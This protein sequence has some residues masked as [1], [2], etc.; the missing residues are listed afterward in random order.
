MVDGNN[1]ES[2][3]SALRQR[4]NRS[5]SACGKDHPETVADEVALGRFLTGHGRAHEAVSMLRHAVNAAHESPAHSDAGRAESLFELALALDK[6]G[7]DTEAMDV[8]WSAYFTFA[9]TL[10]PAATD[11]VLSALNLAE[12]ARVARDFESAER[13]FHVVLAAIHDVHASPSALAAHALNNLAETLLA[14]GRADE[15]APLAEEGLAIRKTLF[16]VASPEYT[17]S[18]CVVAG[19]AA[20]RGDRKR[21]DDAIEELRASS[22]PDALQLP[23]DLI[24]AYLETRGDFAQAVEICEKALAGLENQEQP[25]DESL[26]PDQRI[27]IRFMLAQ[28]L[29]RLDRWSEARTR[30]FE[31]FRIETTF[32]SDAARHR[33]QRQ[34]RLMLGESRRRIATLFDLISRTPDFAANDARDVYE[35]I[36]QRKS[37]ETR[38]LTLQK[39]SFITDR[40]LTAAPPERVEQLRAHLVEVVGDLRSTRQEWL[41]ALLVQSGRQPTGGDDFRLLALQDN[42]ERLERHLASFVGEGSC[43]WAIL[44]ITS[45]TPRLS[46]GEAIVEYFFVEAPTPMYYAFVVAGDEV[47]LTGLGDAASIHQALTQLRVHIVND[48]PR[49]GHPDPTWRRR[50]RFLAN[51]LLR[52]LLPWLDGA[53]TLYV[54]PDAELFTLPFDLL[55]LEDGSLAIDQWTITHLWNGG[56]RAG[57]HV[58]FGS[59]DAPDQAV[60]V[61]ASTATP[62]AS[63]ETPRF[64]P[65]TFARREAIAIAEKI[66]ATHL[67]ADAA[68]KT[69]VLDCGRAEILHFASHSFWIPRRVDA[70]VAPTAGAETPLFR[71]RSMIADPM[72]RSGIA[73]T[74]ADRELNTPTAASPGILFASEVLDLDLRDT[75]LAVL[76]SCQSGIG[77]PR[78]GDGIQGL[79]RAFRAA[80]AGSVVSSLWKVPDEATHDLMV[81]FYNHILTEV[82][83]GESL[84][85][86]KLALRERYPDDPLSWA[87]FVLD[88]DDRP[89]FRFSPIRGLTLATL[90]GVGLSFDKAMEDI[91]EGQ[92]DD[93][94]ESLEFVMESQTADDDL[95]ADAAIERAGVLRQQGHTDESLSA[96]KAIIDDVRTPVDHMRRAVIER[97]LT[98]HMAGDMKGAND[99][100]TAALSDT[101]LPDDERAWMLVNRG[102]VLSSMDD[103]DSAIADWSEVLTITGAS[104]GQRAKALL[105]RANLYLRT[106]AVTHAIADATELAESPDYADF[107]ERPKAHLILALCRLEQ[108]DLLSA[109]DAVHEH[110][111]LRA[112]PAP[113]AIAR[114][115]S[116]SRTPEQLT[117]LIRNLL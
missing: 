72:L 12:T 79:R 36:Q 44:G 82:P 20:N 10:G 68:T 13:W 50:A 37:L 46:E 59:P 98:K 53:R 6:S 15:A 64:A 43:D 47:H 51:R 40:A 103:D 108:G 14:A 62:D 48:P 95:R 81:D 75:D 102:F 45:T 56:E 22:G 73:L 115:V 94:L 2:T 92:L 114:K 54:V 55:P 104:P 16:G 30:L 107:P 110:L 31:A 70:S 86:A 117:A 109:I 21:F 93:A 24:V 101:A 28:L 39:P 100:Y 52:P 91:A 27:T 19:V 11:T 18:L 105:N 87:G 111:K 89:L 41:A 77:D 80:G 23:L 85:K 3:E 35:V 99:D 29:A 76:S 57:F 83:R 106:K 5:R 4:L 32:L 69:A 96:Y 67:D 8:Y 71:A 112:E 97:G 66:S 9:G 65:L 88:G 49:P 38:L 74:G 90:S 63:P 116:R 17:R 61:S 1:P 84:R 113:D 42:V 78:P 60:V 25:P 58:T 33:S 34:M 26:M 7:A